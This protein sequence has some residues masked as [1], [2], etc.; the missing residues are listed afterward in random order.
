VNRKEA[1][2]KAREV[3]IEKTIEEATLESELLLCYALHIDRVQLHLEPE[4]ELT[5]EEDVAFWQLVNRRIKGEPTAYITSHREFYGLDF[6]VTPAVLI[7]RPETEH[8]VEKA[9]ELA[10]SQPVSII[11]DI[12][13]GSGAIAVALA[14]SLTGVGIYAT[15]VSNDALKVARM[16]CQK[17]GVVDRVVFLQGNLL[18]PLP[19]PVDLITANLPYV[20]KAD[21]PGTGLLSFEPKTALDGG[22][23]GLDKIKELAAQLD[24]KLKP[25]GW[26]LLEIGQG[27]AKAVTDL[28][29]RRF[30]AAHIE[31]A[32]DL[33]GI[34]RI[35]S[36]C[37]TASLSNR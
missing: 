15:D 5:P 17:H 29:T 6:L 30:P 21:I 9:L 10:R 24:A 16:N 33:A 37:L 28:L 18:E 25:S 1:L 2:V 26:L 36:L 32:R 23:E 34:E 20:R 19:E 11:A 13:T 4:R 3:L 14:K 31:V 12:G 35:I 7:P 8:L 22:E 27:Q